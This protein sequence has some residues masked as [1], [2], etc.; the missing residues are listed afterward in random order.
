MSYRIT[1]FLLPLL[2]IA[3]LAFYLRI[4]PRIGQR[5]FGIDTWYFLLYA[6]ELRRVKRLPIKLPYFLLEQGEQWYPPALPILLTF[7]RQ[8]FL[9]KYHWAISAI[10]DLAQLIILYSLSFFL[11]RDV[12]MASLAALLYA[13]TPLLVTQNSNLNSRALGA[14]VF[15]AL[16]LSLYMY[17]LSTNWLYL[18]SGI[19]LGVILLNTHRFAS[20]QMSL[21]FLGFSILYSDGIYIYLLLIIYSFAFLLGGRFY[22]NTF[23]G[24]LQIL[25]Y[26]RRNLSFL[27]AHQVY[28]SPIYR[29]EK[30][31]DEMKGTQGIGASKLWFNLAKLH[32]VLLSII[33]LYY[34]FINTKLF[35]LT[36]RFFLNWFFVNFLCVC[37][38]AYCRPL[39]FL[40]EGYRYFMYGVFPAAF[41][42]SKIIFIDAINVNLGFIYLFIL[43]TTNIM[44]VLRGH[45]EQKR[46]ILATVDDNLLELFDYIKKLPRDKIMCLPASHCEHLAYFCRKTT[47]W[48]G[49][50]RG[51]DKVQ[52]IYPVLSKPVEYILN[53]YNIA[54]CLLNKN[55]V[56]LED[57][58]LS[59]GHK[60]IKNKGQYCLLEFSR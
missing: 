8:D 28:H 19:L 22:W 31:A 35:S 37:L 5:N 25:K 56:S 57:L 13:T 33:I 1:S 42:L 3:G 55:Y 14:L 32:F 60:I 29:N 50:G 59:K 10:I 41:L 40:G 47:L 30:R 9:E 7:F 38:I 12:S 26:W 36:D 34:G 46:N 4:K 20:Q 21:L 39:K 15:V 48:G 6:A 18:I 16:M 17:I 53:Y 11:T 52:L 24:H 49:H 2:I 54:Y 23:K 43:F 27:G 45:R 44:L 51:Y 58:H